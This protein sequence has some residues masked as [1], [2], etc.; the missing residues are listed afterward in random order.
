MQD[1]FSF[2]TFLLDVF[3]VFGFI[4][5]FWLLFTVIGDLFRRS[6][7]SGAG[8]VL[9]MIFLIVFPYLGVFA[10]L[11]TQSGNMAERNEA[12]AVKWRQD[13]RNVVG[14]SAADEL[15][16]LDELKARG[17]LTEAEYSKMRARLI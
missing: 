1:G 2:W 15:K 16:K 7:V 3:V 14:F 8:K 13:M 6:D 12:Q 4:L 10:Y 11:F 17:A 9:W 5:W